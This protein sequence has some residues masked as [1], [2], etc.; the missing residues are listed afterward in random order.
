MLES[1]ALGRLAVRIQTTLPV[2]ICE[3]TGPQKH[4]NCT[5]PR[6]L[7]LSIVPATLSPSSARDAH[8]PPGPPAWSTTY[9][10]TTCELFPAGSRPRKKVAYGAIITPHIIVSIEERAL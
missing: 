6:P 3:Y 10:T 9:T 4:R 8:C 5:P 1:M 2:G 7:A